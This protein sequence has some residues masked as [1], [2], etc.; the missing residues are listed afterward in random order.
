MGTPKKPGVL[1]SFVLFRALLSLLEICQGSPRAS[2]LNY[3][4]FNKDHNGSRIPCSPQKPE[5][6]LTSAPPAEKYRRGCNKIN[7]CRS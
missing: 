1:H 7:G 4:A 2:P 5:N 3:Q 6:C